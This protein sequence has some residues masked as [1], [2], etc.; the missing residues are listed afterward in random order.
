MRDRAYGFLSLSDK[1]R[2]SNHLQISEQRHHFFLSYLKTFVLVRPVIEPEPSAAQSGTQPTELTKRSGSCLL[3]FCFITFCDLVKNT[4]NS[5][6]Q[7]QRLTSKIGIPLLPVQ[8]E[9]TYSG[10]YRPHTHVRT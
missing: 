6:R 7:L 9:L 3:W 10:A 4:F 5:D 8:A 2:N 1:T